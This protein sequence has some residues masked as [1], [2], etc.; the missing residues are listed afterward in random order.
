MFTLIVLLLAA[1]TVFYILKTAEVNNGRKIAEN[2]Y[3]HTKVE[4]IQN[5]A[6]VQKLSVLPL[7]DFKGAGENLKTEN[8]VSYLIQA[9]DK[10]ILLDVGLNKGKEH[11]SPLL[12][13]MSELGKSFAEI[14][15]LVF[16]HLHLDHV[17]GMAEQKAGE[18]S[19]SHGKVETPDIPVYAPAPLA[20]SEYNPQFSKIT[21]SEHPTEIAPGIYTIGTIPRQLF[22]IGYIE[23]QALAF[24]LADKGIVLLIGCGHQTIQR[25]LERTKALFDLPIYAVI[26]GLHLPLK[27][28]AFFSKFQWL[29]GSDHAPSKGLKEQ[30]VYNA[31]ESLKAEN[32]QLV[33][34]SPHDSTEWSIRQFRDA[35]GEKY[36]DVKVGKEIIL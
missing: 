26:G 16:S 10:Q 13:N 8:G 25:I 34:L 5:P 7:I 33:A 11:P 21:V 22:L 28:E 2:K 3:A 29:V 1:L 35:F 4:K 15:A 6:S 32:V 9:D 20:P 31:I 12:H 18:F 30:D 14:D 17:G 36:V 19:L 27:G 23:E 24:N